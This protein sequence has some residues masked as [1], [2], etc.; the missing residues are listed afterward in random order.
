M[1]RKGAWPVAVAAGAAGL[2]A[3]GAAAAPAATASTS[4][5]AAAK[6]RITESVKTND[7]A[8]FTAV[9]A[10]GK[11]TG[12][13][14]DGLGIGNAPIAYQLSGGTWK[15]AS[16]P[17][18]K[19]EYVTAAAA[20]SPSNVWAFTQ[21]SIPGFP[22]AT[23]SRVLHYN[24]HTWSV[25]K[26][27][28]DQIEDGLVAAANDV[29]VFGIAT[30]PGEPTLGVWHF[31][32]SKWTQVSKTF[33]G[34]TALSASNV[35]GFSGVNV[36]HWNG[37]RWTAT[38]VKS[39]LPAKNKDETNDPQVDAILALSAKNVYAIGNGSD[40][41]DGGPVVV[42]HYNGSKWS[43]LAQGNFGFGPGATPTDGPQI[44]SD[45]SGGL[46][47][48]MQGPNGSSGYLLHY[49]AGK[50]TAAALP[51]A[52]PKITITAVSQIP[53]TTQQLAGGNTHASG[54]LGTDVVAVLL[55]YS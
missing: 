45:G 16:F 47:I 3:L 25:L 40:E 30:F 52:E 46:W 13:A 19:G 38:S 37:A 41:D 50:L 20:T 12:W 23:P 26:T 5:A 51:L 15:K 44:S 6:W 48:P 11:T 10:T 1:S 39:L 8:D 49:A 55:K 21:G 32:G 43:K 2:L 4:P 42:L 29:W 7:T 33:Q 22:G 54:I 28:S 14:F 24:G 17:A 36:E 27:F 18:K 9:V 53:G 31:N 35:W 34:G